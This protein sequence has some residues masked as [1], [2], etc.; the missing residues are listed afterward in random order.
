MKQQND[1]KKGMLYIVATPI[2][3]M[4]DITLRAIR[5]LKE[6]DMIAAE[7]TRH[8]KKLLNTYQI[9]TS[10]VSLH[11][12]NERAKTALIINKINEGKNVAYV[13]DAGTPCISDPGYFLISKAHDEDIRV[14]P[15]PGPS[16]VIA[17]VS[18]A[19]FP[20]DSFIFCGFL[21]TRENKRRK[22][23]ETLKNEERTIIFYESPLRILST[24]KDLLEILG[25]RKMVLAREITKIFEEIK[26]G[27]ISE[28]IE[29]KTGT[30]IKGEITVIIEGEKIMPAPVSQQEIAQ[31][32][33]EAK[34][35]RKLSLR[36][37]INLVSSETG[38][39][40]KKVYEIGIKTRKG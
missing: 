35:S 13:T 18:A 37:A 29:K 2:G 27:N 11:E 34:K 14:I 39:S 25:D 3:N 5:I 10:L 32:V 23:I 24:F 30:K 4:E 9:A 28:F 22:F 7:D 36:D 8:T 20:A 12:H 33:I 19:G 17:A 6:A 38:I 16:S 40:R 26:R 31:K 15:V 1:L 21:P